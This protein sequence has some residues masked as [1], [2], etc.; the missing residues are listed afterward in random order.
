MRSAVVAGL[1]GGPGVCPGANIG[2]NVAIFE[3]VDDLEYIHANPFRRATMCIRKAQLH[4]LKLYLLNAISFCPSWSLASEA[5][6]TGFY[7]KTL[8][9]YVQ[10]ARHVA[11][12]IAGKG[13]VDPLA[14]LLST[15]MMLRHL[16]LHAFSDTC[17]AT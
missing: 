6:H 5:G 12:D 11:A 10:G 17:A 2:Q 14:M 16:Q 15:S 13:V 3:Q 7:Q 9:R 4:R 8:S 1:C